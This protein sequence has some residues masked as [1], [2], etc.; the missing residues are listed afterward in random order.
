MRFFSWAGVLTIETN[1]SAA[2]NGSVTLYAS[3]IGKLFCGFK[4]AATDL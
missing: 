1:A 4:F 3:D 2:L